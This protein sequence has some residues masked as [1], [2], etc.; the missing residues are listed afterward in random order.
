MATEGYIN[1]NTS[2]AR[3]VY[4]RRIRDAQIKTVV[5]PNKYKDEEHLR[6]NFQKGCAKTHISSTYL[7]M[8]S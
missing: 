1:L 2:D 5:Q 7:C 3:F 8:L 6:P 4:I